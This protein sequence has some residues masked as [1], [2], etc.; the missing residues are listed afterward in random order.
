MKSLSFKQ[1][2]GSQFLNVQEMLWHHISS[3]LAPTS[4]TT[5]YLLSFGITP[6]PESKIWY[7]LSINH[8]VNSVL[9]LVCSEY[10]VTEGTIKNMS[11]P[12]LQNSISTLPSVLL[13]PSHRIQVS[14]ASLLTLIILPIH[15]YYSVLFDYL[16]W[17][18]SEI[19]NTTNEGP[20]PF[21]ITHLL[22]CYPGVIPI[23][24]LYPK[25]W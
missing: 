13:F 6:I 25:C 10:Y 23:L 3:T 1:Y 16:G 4:G 7:S 5:P 14:S 15:W 8:S 24:L 2:L 19:N 12:A 9:C 21:S 11:W 20:W 22:M 18:I 17:S